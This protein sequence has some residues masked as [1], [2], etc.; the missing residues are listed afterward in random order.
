MG[1]RDQ[2][3]D[4][5]TARGLIQ[6]NAKIPCPTREG[7]VLALRDPRVTLLLSQERLRRLLL[8]MHLER[9]R[10]MRQP[11]RRLQLNMS[12]SMPPPSSFHT[13]GRIRPGNETRACAAGRR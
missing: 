3:I 1:R 9:P 13:V 7:K 5:E 2:C 12:R 8:L 11:L 4:A 10:L 6:P